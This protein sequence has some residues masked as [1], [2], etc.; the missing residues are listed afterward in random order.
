MEFGERIPALPEIMVHSQKC[1][2][3]ETQDSDEPIETVATPL[4]PSAEVQEGLMLS[5]ID[6]VDGFLVGLSHVLEQLCSTSTRCRTPFDAVAVPSLPVHVY[7]TRLQRF[8]CCSDSCFVL[9]LIYIDRV[10]QIHH[11]FR[12]THLNVHR[13]LIAAVVVAAKF[14][15]D[16]YYSNEYYASVGGVKPKEMQRLETRLLQLLKYRLCVSPE[17]FTAYL[18]SVLAAT[19]GLP[20]EP[21]LRVTSSEQIPHERC[22]RNDATE[23]AT[24]KGERSSR[25]HRVLYRS[26]AASGDSPA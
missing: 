3:A 9:A 24:T 8:M 17:Q 23:E 18:N 13:L 5:S 14:M 26:R 20:T 2:D 21:V 4:Y 19:G 22:T 25:R 11:D 15:D 12:V 1:E 16:E 6:E 10:L 7:A